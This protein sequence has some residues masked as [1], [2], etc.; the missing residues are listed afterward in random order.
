[1]TKKTIKI[2][3]NGSKCVRQ[4]K[5]KDR[6]QNFQTCGRIKT[7]LSPRGSSQKLARRMSQS[8]EKGEYDKRMKYR[9]FKEGIP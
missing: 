6:N 3:R 7:A 1:M 9:L 4:D 2:T 8:P 5:R